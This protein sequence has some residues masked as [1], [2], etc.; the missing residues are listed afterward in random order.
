V[1]G[2]KDW[3]HLSITTREEGTF[4]FQA[5]T[6]SPDGRTL[7]TGGIDRNI[8]LWDVEKLLKGN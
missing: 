2:R 5:I 1:L 8:N 4:G 7:A 6:F 3:N